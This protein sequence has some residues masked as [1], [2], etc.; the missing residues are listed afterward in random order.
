MRNRLHK[1]LRAF[2]IEPGCDAMCLTLVYILQVG[3]SPEPF[4]RQR[5]N[6]KMSSPLRDTAEGR[7]LIGMGL[8]PNHPKPSSPLTRRSKRLKTAEEQKST[9]EFGAFTKLV[10]QTVSANSPSPFLTAV[11]NQSHE[12]S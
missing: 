9:S 11:H 8:V 6:V 5:G 1:P 12:G 4:S 10:A 3:P 2:D 7:A